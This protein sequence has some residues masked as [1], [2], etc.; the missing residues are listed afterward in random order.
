LGFCQA[1]DFSTF[2][3]LET[4]SFGPTSEQAFLT[5]YRPLVKALYLK[6]RQLESLELSRE[7]DKGRPLDE[8]LHIQ[9]FIRLHGV[10][11]RSA[12][13]DLTHHKTL[14]D[15]DLIARDFNHVRYVAI[16]L[17]RIPDMVCSGLTQPDHTFDGTLIQDIADTENI[18][19]MIAFS[20]LVTE[21]GG[22]AI[23]AWRDSSDAACSL[24]VDSL[25]SLRESDL[26]PALVRF[27]LSKLENVFLRPSWWET[28]ADGAR[29]AMED[30]INHN[31]HPILEVDSAF[32]C[33]DGVRVVNWGVTRIEQKRS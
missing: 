9:E 24:L 8:Q 23:F 5:A 6:M 2:A 33:D 20:L 30:R 25:L 26:P 29:R 18:L 3:P 11:I 32:L 13:S 10:G 17:D 16:H 19:H 1:H 22:A 31:V 27:A 28:L 21:A 15:A 4:Q 12:I 7:A 14:F